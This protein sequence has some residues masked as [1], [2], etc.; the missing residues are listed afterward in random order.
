MFWGFFSKVNTV[1]FTKISTYQYPEIAPCHRNFQVFPF[2]F[3]FF[4]RRLSSQVAGRGGGTGGVCSAKKDLY[5]QEL[6][7]NTQDLQVQPMYLVL[8][9]CVC[10]LVAVCSSEL[11]SL[12]PKS[13]RQPQPSSQGAG[14]LATH[15]NLGI[16][17]PKGGCYL[18]LWTS[19]ISKSARGSLQ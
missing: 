14:C 16:S 3:I 15:K 1:E 18:P 9:G 7:G 5:L 17:R 6:C 10:S 11:I 12:R 4:S 19:L 8:H 2:S 13:P